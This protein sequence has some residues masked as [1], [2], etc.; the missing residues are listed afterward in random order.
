VGIYAGDAGVGSVSATT[1]I[2]L[3]A[4]N[5][6]TPTVTPVTKD[7]VRYII[8]AATAQSVFGTPFGGGRNLSQD[9]VT[10]ITN[11]ALFKNVK[12]NERASLEF[13]AT[14]QNVFNHPNFQS[15]D[16]V[17]ENAGLPKNLQAPGVGFA[18]PSVTNDVIGNA[19]G[20]RIIRFGLTFRF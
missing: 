9:A 7:Q 5:G 14:L 10:N 6:A 4:L 11:L 15:I 13:Q 17:I 8:N 16:P 20:N 2:S 3:N 1:L 19:L 12:F 18:D